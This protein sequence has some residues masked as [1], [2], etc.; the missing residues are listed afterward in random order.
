MNERNEQIRKV[1]DTLQ[2][3]LRDSMPMETVLKSC[4][5]AFPE[6]TPLWD[7]LSAKAQADRL[8]MAANLQAQWFSS[9]GWWLARLF[10]WGVLVFAVAFGLW[11]GPRIVDPLTYAILGAVTYYLLIQVFT[12]IRLKR[13]NRDVRELVKVQHSKKREALENLDK[14]WRKRC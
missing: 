14:E 13:Q 10:M 6:Q 8:S 1:L 11:L 3:D 4:V 7:Y 9:L 12:P 2:E 5:A